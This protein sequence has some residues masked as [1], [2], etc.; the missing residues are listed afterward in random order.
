[1]TVPQ[2]PDYY[3]P[4]DADARSAEPFVKRW[5]RFVGRLALV[6]GSI[7]LVLVA[8][9]AALR[10][11]PLLLGHDFANGALSRYSTRAGG[12]HFFDRR[13]RMKF[14]IPNHR[15]TMYYNGYVWE[16]QT[17]ALGF[18]ND[19]LH[20]PADL[21]LL[22]DSIVYGHG[23]NFEHTVGHLLERRTG[24]RVAN[25]GQPRDC[26]FQEAYLLTANLPVFRPR[27]VVH[28]FTSND[29]DDLYVYLANAVMEAFIAQPVDRI[30]YPSR[31]DPAQ[32][33]AEHEKKIRNRPLLRRLDEE[34]YV[35]KIFQ[36]LAF[37]VR[38]LRA[39][40]PHAEAAYDPRMRHDV[41]SVSTNPASLGWRYTTHA[42][43]YMK[44]LTDRAG[45]R[46][47]MAPFAEGRQIEILRGIAARHG[48]EII[49]TAPLFT[50]PTILP[51]DG[52]LTPH[53][54]RVMSDLIAAHLER[55]P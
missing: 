8:M 36:W 2:R 33:L 5:K 23:V 9:E 27:V 39:S 34:A 11:W 18:R 21:V 22:G 14:M 4:R 51:N 47:V 30:T 55:R 7:L 25:L 17:D 10:R 35:I 26:V 38:E 45:A 40:V 13:L 44:Y 50:G 48:I 49:D 46:F 31:T 42:L 3:A 53:G 19:P 28:V 52:H 24:L 12:I 37:R 32:L 29:I 1:L 16:H 43:A 20:V 6:V 54:A 41:A 15:T